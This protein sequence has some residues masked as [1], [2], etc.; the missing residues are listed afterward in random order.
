MGKE[1]LENILV[2]SISL[3]KNRDIFLLDV[4]INE[5]SMTHKFAEYLQQKVGSDWNVDCEYNRNFKDKKFVYMLES[6]ILEYEVLEESRVSVRKRVFPDIIVHKRTSEKNLLVIEAKK[7]SANKLSVVF[8]EEKLTL[9]K[10]QLGYEY[11]VF[12]TF[13]TENKNINYEFI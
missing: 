9:I 5:R 12:L 13:D 4:N 3:F 11:A 8:D 1:R 6:K 2:D 7:S 10:G